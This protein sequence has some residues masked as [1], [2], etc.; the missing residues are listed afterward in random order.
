LTLF[1]NLNKKI[2]LLVQMFPIQAYPFGDISRDKFLQ[3]SLKGG[4]YKISLGWVDPC[5]VPWDRTPRLFKE[6]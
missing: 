4:K 5:K 3:V 1:Y 2:V 6:C